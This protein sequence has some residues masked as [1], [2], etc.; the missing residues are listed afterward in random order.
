MRKGQHSVI[1]AQHCHLASRNGNIG[2]GKGWS[3]GE[4]LLACRAFLEAS[5]DSKRGSAQR[6]DSF[7]L[8]VEKAFDCLVALK[9][10]KTILLKSRKEPDLLFLNNSSASKRSAY[11]L[12]VTIRTSLYSILLGTLLRQT[13]FVRPLRFTI[14][15]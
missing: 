4:N 9:K 1:R 10:T 13:S 5:E 8:R 3:D 12:R 6:T 2:T 14:A 15:V 7:E 11:C